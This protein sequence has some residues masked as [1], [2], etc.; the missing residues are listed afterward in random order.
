[1]AYPSEGQETVPTIK[2]PPSKVSIP[3]NLSF[4]IG[5]PIELCYAH[6]DPLSLGARFIKAYKRHFRLPFIKIQIVIC[7]KPVDRPVMLMAQATEHLNATM[8][9]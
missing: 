9:V 7:T 1:M 4:K 2:K 8:R 6:G 3:N 5:F